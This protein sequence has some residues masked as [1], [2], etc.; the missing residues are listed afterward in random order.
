MQVT[1]FYFTAENTIDSPESQS[2]DT[3][4]IQQEVNLPEAKFDNFSKS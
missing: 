3:G 2:P 1:V 4:N